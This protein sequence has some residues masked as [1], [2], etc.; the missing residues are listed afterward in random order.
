MLRRSLFVHDCRS[1]TSAVDSADQTL[2]DMRRHVRV[3]GK[4]VVASPLISFA[5]IREIRSRT[6]VFLIDS[7]RHESSCGAGSTSF[8]S[9][10]EHA[11]KR[12][13]ALVDPLPALRHE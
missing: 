11:V 9:A 6:P 10:G 8:K 2:S 5:A 7:A 1:A 13:A 4:I 12:R 3:I